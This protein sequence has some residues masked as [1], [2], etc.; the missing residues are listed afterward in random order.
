MLHCTLIINSYSPFL[1]QIY[2]G[3]CELEAAGKISLTVKK[4]KHFDPLNKLKPYTEVIINNNI[5]VLIDTFDQGHLFAENNLTITPDFYFKRSYS[6]HFKKESKWEKIL[7]PL[8]FNYYVTSKNDKIMP[9]SRLIKGKV[10]RIIN[11]SDKLLGTDMAFNCNIGE[12]EF[13]PELQDNCNIL[14]TTRVWD[15]S[16]MT[17]LSQSETENRLET[18]E[19][20][21]MV[22]RTCKTNFK[23]RFI[24]GL[25]RTP[26]SE[27]KYSDC[28]LD[29][30]KIFETRN[31][32][33]NIR[34]SDICISTLGLFHANGWKF[35]E[36]FAASRAVITEKMQYDVIGDFA[37]GKHVLS[38]TDSDSLIS[39]INYL[40]MNKQARLEMMTRNKKYYTKYIRPDKIVADLIRRASGVVL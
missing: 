40:T 19:F 33:S 20:R 27:K 6:D 21:A 28:L 23:E 37:E 11:V 25:E 13:E 38:F 9:F 35:A 15:P 32:L 26:F 22:I 34:K 7:Q 29:S 10:K 8:G 1:Q 4:S 14:F 36:Y 17:G 16:E 2:T 39:H 30:N 18:N 24:G 5:N 12:Y 3:F 31:Y